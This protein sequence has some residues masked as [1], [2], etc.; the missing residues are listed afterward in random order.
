MVPAGGRLRL[1]LRLPRARRHMYVC[2]RVRRHNCPR[3]TIIN[4]NQFHQPTGP[5]NYVWIVSIWLVLSA[6]I[7]LCCLTCTTRR[8]VRPSVRPTVCPS[9]DQ[10]HQT[11]APHTTPL[12]HNHHTHTQTAAWTIGATASVLRAP[13]A[14]TASATAAA[15]ASTPAAARG[16]GGGSGDGATMRTGTTRCTSRS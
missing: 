15:S 2:V 5:V 7:C 3:P 8:C 9:A 11:Q 6:L 14:A 12:T 13:A 4:P 10:C 16:S 1:G